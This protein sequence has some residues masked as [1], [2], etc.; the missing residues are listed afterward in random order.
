MEKFSLDLNII[1]RNILETVA[2]ERGYSNAREFINDIVNEF[3]KG[4]NVT[5]LT[6]KGKARK[7]KNIYDIP[8]E[9]N[10]FYMTLS[11]RHSTTVSAIIFRYV[12]FPYIAKKYI[13]MLN[14]PFESED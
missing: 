8:Q 6:C 9:H 5:K 2:K 7:C 4:V 12:I 10:D 13:D 3:P 1:D 11:C 14:Q